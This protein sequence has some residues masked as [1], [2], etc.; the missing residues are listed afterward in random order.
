ML[1]SG[2]WWLVESVVE[3]NKNAFIVNEKRSE[4]FFGRKKIVAKKFFRNVS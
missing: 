2:R 3:L 1:L 4:F